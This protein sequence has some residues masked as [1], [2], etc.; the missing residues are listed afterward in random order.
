MIFVGYRAR[1]NS[2]WG[3][4]TSAINSANV[5]MAFGRVNGASGEDLWSFGIV[6]GGLAL[7]IEGGNQ[8][9]RRTQYCFDSERYACR[10]AGVDNLLDEGEEIDGGEYNRD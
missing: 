3:V 10:R 9:A 4:T 2:G 6:G 8:Q 1:S 7:V 5:N